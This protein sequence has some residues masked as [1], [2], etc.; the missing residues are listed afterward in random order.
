MEKQQ[1]IPLSLSLIMGRSEIIHTLAQ[2][3]VTI[4]ED[5]E[6]DM[7]GLDNDI[8]QSIAS[9]RIESCTEEERINIS[10]FMREVW[11]Q[12]RYSYFWI[13]KIELACSKKA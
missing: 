11:L 1:N 6:D 4:I 13:L 10:Y 2:V 12:D 7:I 3:D 9:E 8:V 5:K